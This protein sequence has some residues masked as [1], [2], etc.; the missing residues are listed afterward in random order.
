MAWM[1]YSEYCDLLCKMGGFV[2]IRWVM[3]SYDVHVLHESAAAE[4]RSFQS[5]LFDS[6]AKE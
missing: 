2:W 6:H 4:F 1:F 3:I 5:H